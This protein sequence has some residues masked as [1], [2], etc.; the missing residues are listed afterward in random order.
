MVDV[1]S[2]FKKYNINPNG[3]IHRSIEGIG[4]D[5]SESSDPLVKSNSTG[6]FV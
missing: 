3:S 2:V 1:Q 4:T 5:I 6:L